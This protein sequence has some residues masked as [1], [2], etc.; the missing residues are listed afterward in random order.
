[1]SVTVYTMKVCPYCVKAK[2]LLKARGV[3]FEEVLLLETD[4]AGWDA[5]FS[6]STLKTVPQIFQGDRLIGGYSDLESLDQKDQ[7]KS[8]K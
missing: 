3:Q 6:K 5:L 7:L 1:M 2:N 8:L 4:E